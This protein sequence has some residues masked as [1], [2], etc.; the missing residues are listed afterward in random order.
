MTN[1]L[2]PADALAPLV[3]ISLKSQHTEQILGLSPQAHCVQFFEVH[4]ENLM[5]EGGAP[6]AHMQAVASKYRLSVH[7]TGLSLGSAHGLNQRHLHRFREVVERYQPFLVSE[8]LAWCRGPDVYYN[9]LLPLPY[10]EQTLGVVADNIA[11]VQD[12]LGRQIL[13]E[14]PSAYLSFRDSFMDE[15][16]FLLELVRRTGCGLLLDVNNV[17]VTCSNL[18]LNAD[19]YLARIPASAVGEVHLAGHSVVG[20]TE[21]GEPTIRVDDHGSEVCPEVWQHYRQWLANQEDIARLHTLIEWDTNVPALDVLL[22]QAKLA[23]DVIKEGCSDNL[24]V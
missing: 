23:R 20:L 13:V 22:E 19:A 12:E 7:G 1:E 24:S 4:A 18:A 2:Q 8:H 6:H 9:D 10:N 16:S 3:G 21:S 15:P 5:G 17:F 11:R 14:N